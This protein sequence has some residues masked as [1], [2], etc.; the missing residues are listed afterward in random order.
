MPPTISRPPAHGPK[1]LRARPSGSCRAEELAA[2]LADRASR[3]SRSAALGRLTGGRPGAA[4]GLATIR[5][6]SWPRK[7][8][9]DAAG[10]AG[11]GPAPAPGRATG[12]DRRRRRARCCSGRNRSDRLRRGRG[13]AARPRQ[14][15]IWRR[16]ASPAERR[17]AVTQIIYVWRDVARDLAVAARGG[18][19]NCASTSFWTSSARQVPRS[20]P[21]PS[22]SS[23]A[24]RFDWPCPR[25]LCQSRACAR[26]A[27]PRV[28]HHGSRVSDSESQQRLEA[29]VRGTVQGVG[30]RWFVVRRAS[31]L[32]LPAGRQRAAMDRPGSGRG[33]RRR[34]TSCTSCCRTDQPVLTSTQVDAARLPADR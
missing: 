21:R 18:S 27:T 28:A 6:R 12:A 25:C 4:I 26:R 13:Q 29:T 33:I 8:C 17:A 2:I 30:F 15:R 11:R 19:A 23:S 20:V 31:E 10:S 14:V 1:P 9:H 32:G 3:C 16:R 22:R 5:T 34:W 7:G 24:H